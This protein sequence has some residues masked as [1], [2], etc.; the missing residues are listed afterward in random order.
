M[1]EWKGKRYPG[2]QP[3]SCRPWASAGHA[4]L[5]GHAQAQVRTAFGLELLPDPRLP[6]S[7]VQLRWIWEVS[8]HTLSL[9]KTSP[10]LKHSF[11]C[12]GR[13]LARTQEGNTAEV[14]LHEPKIKQCWWIHTLGGS[15]CNDPSTPLN[16]VSLL[17]ILRSG[18]SHG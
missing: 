6:S 17:Q 11:Y 13:K 7:L 5:I 10:C 18:L 3:A 8:P 16:T 2:R 15:A 4:L 1:S 9:R 14:L 12:I